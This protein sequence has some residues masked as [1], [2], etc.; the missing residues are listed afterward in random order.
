M[1]SADQ[2]RLTRASS[3][4]AT[5]AASPRKQAATPRKAARQLSATPGPSGGT[6]GT[7][8]TPFGSAVRSRI[9]ATRSRIGAAA[10]AASQSEPNSPRGASSGSLLGEDGPALLD[11]LLPPGLPGEGESFWAAVGAGGSGA[12]TPSSSDN[13]RVYVRVRPPSSR[14]AAAGVPPC[15]DVLGG[16]TVVLSEAGRLDPFTATFDRV[17]GPE[18]GQ[19]EVYAAVGAQMVENCLAGFNSSIFVYG[20]TGAGKTHTITGDVT[21]GEDGAL[22]EQCGLTLRV[23][24][25]LFDRITD[26]EQGGVRYTV[27][28]SYCEV[29]NEE[30][31]DLLAA[32]GARAAGGLAIRE[33]DAHRGVCVEGL[34]EH[35]AVNADDVMGLVQRG[36]ANRHTAATRMNER[37]SRSH[38]VF[39]AVVEAAEAQADSG[40]TQVR[41]A[42]LNL[43]DLAGSE[44]VGKSGAT[45]E[46]LT[47]AKSINKSLTTLGRVVTA[48]TERQQHVPYRDSR[49]T[50]LLKE[51]L[52][53]NSKTSL[54]ACVSPCED[55]A[56]ES[57]STLVF[58]QGAKRIRNKAVVNQDTVGDLRALQLENAR[59][60]RELA[61]KEGTVTA[62]LRTALAAAQAQAAAAEERASAT[63]GRVAAAEERHQQLEAA[64]NESHSSLQQRNAELG[65]VKK[66]LEEVKATCALLQKDREQ[67]IDHNAALAERVDSLGGSLERADSAAQ[68]WEAD[69][70][71]AQQRCEAAAG[72]QRAAE[73][74]SRSLQREVERLGADLARLGAELEASREELEESERAKKALRRE[75]EQVLADLRRQQR[76]AADSAELAASR[77]ARLRGELA[78][79]N[80]TLSARSQRLH[81]LE[82]TLAAE[83][84]ATAKYRKM[85]GEIG[86][87]IDW[88]QSTSPLPPVLGGRASPAGYSSLLG[89]RLSFGGGGGLVSPLAEASNQLRASLGSLP[90]SAGPRPKATPGTAPPSLSPSKR[91]QVA[92]PAGRTPVASPTKFR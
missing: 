63:D 59:L 76:E 80:E 81:D 69:A 11:E 89:G 46:Q 37:S 13:I 73:E 66:E 35:V 55:S 38:S 74:Q 2:P 70:Q 8:G 22:A 45:G 83:T 3:R 34:T 79:V 84:V 57:H 41:F 40:V 30:L 91:L 60:Q 82:S 85:V 78:E 33:G 25:Q 58:A 1:S 52:G 54:V 64:L 90:S 87:L 6:P 5:P 51:S 68:R 50:F 24:R 61:K 31:S 67:L 49:L 16:Q 72:G 36:S 23:F 20:Q 44:R 56:Q 14:E 48:L 53:G 71:A 65:L 26:E 12:P 7:R 39:T 77:E 86:K 42:K 62:E 27:K 18:A 75:V 9:P 17:F 32:P 92:S 88:A 43:I 29:Y 19:E 15:L 21:R 47:E 10:R 4:G 28:C